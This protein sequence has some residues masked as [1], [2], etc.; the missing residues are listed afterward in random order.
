MEKQGEKERNLETASNIAYEK[1][2]VPKLLDAS[3]VCDHS[4]DICILLYLS[5]CFDLIKK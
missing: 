5:L 1:W 4:D 2:E 3:D